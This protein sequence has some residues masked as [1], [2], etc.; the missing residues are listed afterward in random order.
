MRREH[1][2][3]I[4]LPTFSEFSERCL[5]EDAS[6]LAPTTRSDLD[7]YLREGGPLLALV[8]EVRRLRKTGVVTDGGRGS[9]LRSFFH[10]TSL[11]LTLGA[12]G[13]LLKG[14][15]SL[16]VENIAELSQTRLGYSELVIE[17]LATLQADT[18]VGFSLLLAA[19][20]CQLCNSPV[21]V[22]VKEPGRKRFLGIVGAIIVCAPVLGGSYWWSS[23]ADGRTAKDVIQFLESSPN[24]G[25]TTWESQQ[26]RK[27]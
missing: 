8:G 13:F 21:A 15:L 7:S 17:N 22:E 26:E 27:Q 23:G 18:W 6:H 11:I 20:F 12:S 5:T 4:E 3:V 10:F 1:S 2:W 19:F 14:N 16:S 9:M 24:Q 25:Q